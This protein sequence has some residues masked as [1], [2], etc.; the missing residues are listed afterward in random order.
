MTRSGWSM[1]PVRPASISWRRSCTATTRRGSRPWMWSTAAESARWWPCRA[2]SPTSTT[3]RPTS[4]MSSTTAVARCSISAATRSTSRGCCS[5]VSR[6]ESRRP[7]GAIR[8]PVSTSSRA[9]SWI[10]RM[11]SPPSP[12]RCG[13]SPISGWTSTAGK[14]ESRSRSPS[15]SR[16]TGPPGSSS[17]PAGSPV[18]PD[19]E[20]VEFPTADPYTA[21][22]EDFATAVLDGGPTPV[23]PEDAVANLR[24]IDAIF[25]AAGSGVR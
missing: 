22:A 7:C 25:A 12:A 23:P 24:V 14:A 11:G 8:P 4:A 10:S 20:V 16:P 1:S 9:R 17:R 18:A 6:P 19:T 21:E 15:T 13:A 3:T 2:G 5:T